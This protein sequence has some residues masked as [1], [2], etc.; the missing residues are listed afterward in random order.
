MVLHVLVIPDIIPLTVPVVLY[1]PGLLLVC[2]HPAGLKGLYIRYIRHC[3]ANKQGASTSIYSLYPC[4]CLSFLPPYISSLFHLV[5][6]FA[7]LPLM[8]CWVSFS[9]LYG[10]PA[11]FNLLC[12][13]CL[14]L[15]Y[16]PNG[17]Y[18]FDA[19][20]CSVSSLPATS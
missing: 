19:Y 15:Q 5:V 10:L 9:E 18:V 12:W 1:H 11:A 8:A 4:P 7:Y 14:S 6:F 13:Y 2:W 17:F 16:I 3:E 20:H